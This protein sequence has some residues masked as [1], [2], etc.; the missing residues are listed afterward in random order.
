MSATLPPQ[1]NWKRIDDEFRA[2]YDEL[3][4]RDPASIGPTPPALSDWPGYVAPDLEAP[5][6]PQ[7]GK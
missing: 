2:F 5:T 3:G 6:G 1:R 7:I 4:T